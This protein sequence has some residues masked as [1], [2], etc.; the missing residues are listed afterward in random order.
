MASHQHNFGPAAPPALVPVP[1]PLEASD[2]APAQHGRGHRAALQGHPVPPSPAPANLPPAP[3]PTPLNKPPP[4]PSVQRSVKWWE[5]Q[6]YVAGAST[7]YQGHRYISDAPAATP[8]HR[9]PSTTSLARAPDPSPS[10][11]SFSSG[12]RDP[13]SPALAGPSTSALGH[14]RKSNGGAPGAAKRSRTPGGPPPR[15]DDA[16]DGDVDGQ[17]QHGAVAGGSGMSALRGR[18]SRSK[19]TA[20]F[21]SCKPDDPSDGSSPASAKSVASPSQA[22]LSRP[23]VR[24][25]VRPTFLYLP[26]TSPLSCRR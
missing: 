4:T 24:L 16:D 18:K 9:P 26:R 12:R 5:V 10:S 8:E 14:K 22:Q 15:I 25:S 20:S 3:H 19:G 23:K 7:E 11:S 1:P 2:A 21:R 13:A 17:A 6:A